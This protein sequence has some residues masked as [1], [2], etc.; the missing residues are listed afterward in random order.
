ML[1]ILL[2]VVLLIEPSKAQELS[3]QQGIFDDQKSLIEMTEQVPNAAPV[4]FGICFSIQVETDEQKITLVETIKHPL[5]LKGNGVESIGYSVPKY[6]Y[7]ENQVAKGCVVYLATTSAELSIGT[8][9]F[10]ISRNG[11]DILRRVFLVN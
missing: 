7:V 5:I 9:E 4:N 10:S 6:F 1:K 8:W 3:V 2:M 11:K